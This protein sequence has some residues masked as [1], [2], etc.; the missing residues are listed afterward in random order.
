MHFIVSPLVSVL[1]I[2]RWC[3]LGVDAR[4]GGRGGVECRHE[5]DVLVL[6]VV[7]VEHVGALVGAIPGHSRS[8]GG[9]TQAGG[10]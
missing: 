8:G 6:Q 4:V 7:A 10:Q 1:S 3:K 2:G 9:G 5:A